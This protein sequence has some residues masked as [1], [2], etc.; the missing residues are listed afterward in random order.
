[1][2]EPLLHM[3]TPPEWRDHLRSGA[4]APTV[5]EFVHLSTPDQ[6]ALP[7]NRLHPG[8][9]DLMLL[10]LD[11]GRIGVPVKW[12]PGVPTDPASMRFPHA[13]GPVPASAVIAVLPYRPRPDGGFDA[14]AVPTLDAAARAALATPSH[15]RRLATREVPVTGGVAVLTDPVPRSHQHNQLF[16]DGDVDAALVAADADR[17]LDGK[18]HRMALLASGRTASGLAALGWEVDELVYMAAPAG[19]AATGRVRQIGVE[20]ARAFWDAS[21][22][23]TIPAVDAA[24]LAQLTDR[25]ALE[26]QVVDLRCLAVYDGGELV[27]TAL[28]KI[29]GGTAV[30]DA[31]ETHPDHHGRGHGTAM[32]TEA[33]ALAGGAGCDLVTLEAAAADWP[34]H[35]YGRLGFTE[36]GRGWS[37]AR[38]GLAAPSG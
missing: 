31:V 29:D 35:W 15:L 3:A 38:R 11:P 30:V 27:A 10:V 37:A 19:G 24:T 18:A 7:A 16:V 9:A 25:Y 36:V 13:Y 34:R 21:W 26:A 6:V 14:P 33:L 12:E 20:D 2:T 5:A 4:I 28:L 1:M 23:R 22:R 32:I 17:V 8:A